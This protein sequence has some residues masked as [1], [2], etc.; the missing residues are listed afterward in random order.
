MNN[1]KDRDQTA[2]IDQASEQHVGR[3]NHLVST[4]NWDKGDIICAWRADLQAAGAP[5][6]QFS[7]EAW[8]NR[9]GN[10]S[11]QHVGRLRRV[12]ARFGQ[13]WHDYQGLFWSH[14][15]SALEW[16]DAEMWL[17]GGVQNGWSVSQMR[18]ARWEALGAPAELK[19][20]EQDIILSEFDEDVAVALDSSGSK[21]VATR[22]DTVR[23]PVE[24]FGPDFGDEPVADL[25]AD[26][27][28]RIRPF[29][30]LPELPSD[31]SQ[32][33][34]SFKMA[35]LHHKMDDWQQVTRDDVVSTL[36][37]LKELATA[38]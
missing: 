36:E 2:V 1:T 32:S 33:F 31:L 3:W 27:E 5:S 6:S 13:V 37:A 34:E 23:D 11:P 18:V 35:I 17:E 7:D 12:F 8:S 19:P 10:V 38:P 16:E 24:S 25:P 9:V 4:T 21:S 22:V 28:P 29:S 15:Q 30:E 14:F 20:R 26:D